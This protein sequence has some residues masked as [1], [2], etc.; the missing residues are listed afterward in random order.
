MN[1]TSRPTAVRAEAPRSV[2]ADGP[3]SVPGQRS[4]PARLLVLVSGSGTN[5]QA[6]I[7]AEAQGVLGGSDATGRSRARVVAV[8]SDRRGVYALERA[9]S[10][11]LP[12]LLE[13]PDRGLP[14][15]ERRRDLSDRL[16][17]VAREYQADFVVLAG[18][19]SIL[20]GAFIEAYAGRI[21]NL[22][23]ALLPKFGGPGMWGHHVHEAVLAAGE[24]ESGCTV[25][26]VDEGT[27]TGPILLQRRVPVLPGDSPESLAER[28]HAQ[29]HLAIVEAIE[30]LVGSRSPH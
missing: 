27:D 28:I 20:Q 2:P 25:H 17:A 14:V 23:P 7:D 9:R 12:A 3:R 24:P 10:A 6:L 5:L 26:L 16:L 22:H 29:E 4:G 13:A 1:G 18:F 19:L 8:V 11:A 15:A 30:V 21:V